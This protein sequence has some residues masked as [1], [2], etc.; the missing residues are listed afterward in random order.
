MVAKMATP[1]LI[2][3]A[4][5]NKR[6]ADIAIAAGFR[7][8][9]QLPDTIYHPL[10]FADQN[11]KRPDRARYFAS[12]AQHRPHLATV[13]DW[14]HWDQRAEVLH[15]AEDAAQHVE[16]VLIIPKVPGGITTLPRQI[17][18]KPIRLGYSVP[19]RY[20]ATHVPIWEFAG[21]PIHLLGGSPHKQME[22]YRYLPDDIISVDGNMINKMA[23]QFNTV[24][25]PGT[26]YGTSNRYWPTLAELDRAMW[27][28]DA[29]YEAFRR[30]CHNIIQT[31]EKIS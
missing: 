31:W 6:F 13:L 1:T 10:Y 9:A 4:G 17:G 2:Y 23:T 24:W 8:G 30:S 21:W 26:A 18:G 27:G 12:L 19:T 3:C 20:A 28:H 16:H 29:C 5:G 15:W 7:Y 14:E 25:M 11:W 22:I